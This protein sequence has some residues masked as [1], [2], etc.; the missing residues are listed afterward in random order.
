[1][2]PLAYLVRALFRAY[3]PKIENKVQTHLDAKW[4]EGRVKLHQQIA[5]REAKDAARTA[6]KRSA[7]PPSSYAGFAD[8]TKFERSVALPANRIAQGER[9]DGLAACRTRVFI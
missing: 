4:A 8:L 5:A 7:A 1:M 3:W 9:M 6:R 2:N